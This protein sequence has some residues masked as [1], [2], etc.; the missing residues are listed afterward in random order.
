MKILLFILLLLP[1][2]S[3]AQKETPNL[4]I[5]STTHLITYTDVVTV[6]GNKDQLYSRAREW[7]AKT[8]NSSQKVIQMDDT[9]KIVGKALI[10]MYARNF[11][12]VQGESGFMNYTITIAFKNGKFKYTISDFYHTMDGINPDYGTC[13]DMMNSKHQKKY[14]N[15]YLLQMDNNINSLVQNLKESMANPAI[16]DKKNNW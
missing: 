4:P 10:Q 15:N 1:I 11:I 5:D 16:D 13:E 3:F 2:F 8:Y 7:F 12:G 14:F 9:S 6:S